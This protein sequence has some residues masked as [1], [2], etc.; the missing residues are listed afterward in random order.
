[1]AYRSIEGPAKKGKI[2]SADQM[3]GGHKW[4]VQL[5]RLETGSTITM[6]VPEAIN[7]ELNIATFEGEDPAEAFDQ[8]RVWAAKEFGN[9]H[10]VQ[11]IPGKGI[12]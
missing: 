7:L 11:L 5:E 6:K 2:M 8:L 12:L 9:F 1:M 4:S 10:P 3:Y